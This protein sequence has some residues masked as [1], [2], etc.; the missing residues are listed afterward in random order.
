MKMAAV[1]KSPCRDLYSFSMELVDVKIEE[2]MII[3]PK[4]LVSSKQPISFGVMS[5]DSEDPEDSE[6]SESLDQSI[7][8]FTVGCAHYMNSCLC[9]EICQ[10]HGE[11][12][13]CEC[14]DENHCHYCGDTVLKNPLRCPHPKGGWQGYYCSWNCVHCHVLDL[15]DEK[16]IDLVTEFEQMPLEDLRNPSESEDSLE[17][18]HKDDLQSIQRLGEIV[19]QEV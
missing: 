2:L 8:P 17:E 15:E 11:T 7:M 16:L 6:D 12:S 4:S 14:D 19:T 1:L 5:E 10:E 18:D 9:R 3:E 13:C